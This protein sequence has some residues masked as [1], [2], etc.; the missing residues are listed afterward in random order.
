[1]TI[2]KELL[3]YTSK[4]SRE[5]GSPSWEAGDSP[6][7]T[8]KPRMRKV[9]SIRH[10]L[11]VS[12]ATN[13]TTFAKS[14]SEPSVRCKTDGACTD[15]TVSQKNHV[16]EYE[17]ALRFASLSSTSMGSN[18]TSTTFRVREG[19]RP[20]RRNSFVIRHTANRSLLPR[21]ITDDETP[22][23]EETSYN[24]LLLGNLIDGSNGLRS[25]DNVE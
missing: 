12:V 4:K 1:M 9:P 17:T 20:C 8:M 23:S 16:F 14:Y 11:K 3:L 10:K 19:P 2:A 21:T 5:T 13:A 18:T 15:T 25:Q 24:L 6:S 22:M 7:T